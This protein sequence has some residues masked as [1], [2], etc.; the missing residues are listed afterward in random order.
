MITQI[1]HLLDV[2]QSAGM[3]VNLDKTAFLLRVSG[4]QSKS[5]RKSILIHKDSKLRLKI[6]RLS[7]EDTLIPVVKVHTY[8]GAKI[9]FYAFEDQTL[10]RRLRI[11]RATFL[12]LRP[13]LLQRHTYPL[14]MRLKLWE[15]CV[16]SSCLHSLQAVGITQKG[17][18]RLHQRFLAD[19]RQIARSP[20]HITHESS[21]ALCSR[22]GISLPLPGLIDLWTQQYERRCEKWAGLSTDDFLCTFDIH[23]HHALVMQACTPSLPYVELSEIQLCPYCDFST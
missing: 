21:E 4:T 15:T 7:Q 14:A 20:S 2:L 6:P 9:S 18:L 23:A 22:L 11:G 5:I 16:R 10:A 13:W 3:K 1:G 19:L 8:L 12:R 17:A